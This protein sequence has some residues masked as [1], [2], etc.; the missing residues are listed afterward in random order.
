MRF[1]P[2]AEE[3]EHAEKINYWKRTDSETIAD[4][5]V[6]RVRRDR[7]VNP[8]DDQAHDFFVIEAPDWINIIPLTPERDVVMIEQYRHGIDAVTLEIPG[9]WSTP[10]KNRLRQPRASF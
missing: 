3:L 9:A 2:V 10:G 5:R 6:F 8:R 4:C 1:T 7:T